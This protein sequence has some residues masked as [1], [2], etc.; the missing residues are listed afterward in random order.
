[1][2]EVQQTILIFS[3]MKPDM[4]HIHIKELIQLAEQLSQ[5]GTLRCVIAGDLNAHSQILSG[6][7]DT[8]MRGTLLEEALVDLE[9]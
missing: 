8:N 5:E 6:D 7:H 1:M 3:Y 9:F 2:I 4:P